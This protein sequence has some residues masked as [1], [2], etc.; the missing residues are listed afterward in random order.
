M[1]FVAAVAASHAP[2]IL[3]E[4]GA[5]WDEFMAL[6]YRMAP[7]A[8][9]TKPSLEAQQKLR[10]DAEKAYAALRADLETARPDVL[11]VVANDQFVNFA[12]NNI[13]TFFITL[14][15]EVKGQFTRHRFHYR[16]DKELG[17]AILKAGIDAGIDFSFGEYIELQHTQTVPLHFLLPEPKIPILPI[18]VNTWVEPIPTPRRCFQVGELIGKVAEGWK[19]RVAILAT[20]GLSHFPGSPR[21]GEID[22]SFDHKLLEILREGK[23]RSLADY[24]VEEI[25]KAGDSEF[26]NWM[27]AIGSV[28][29]A[30][31]KQ[32]FYMPDHVATGWGFV[33]W[34]I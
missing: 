33:S 2:N 6:H 21:I 10:R 34:K 20:G 24:S 1:P 18:Y 15:D 13:P 4:P 5:E 32:T 11:I 28:G 29:D 7:Q 17:R 19:E 22:T 12:Y 9:S 31:A 14:A 27:V 26:L 8:A 30:K 16:N 23:G 25:C 3:L